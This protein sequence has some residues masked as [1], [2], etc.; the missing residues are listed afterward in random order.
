LWRSLMKSLVWLSMNCLLFEFSP[1]L[2][3]C[4]T[5]FGAGVKCGL[6]C[7]LFLQSSTYSIWNSFCYVVI[8]R[9]H[10]GYNDN[11]SLIHWRPAASRC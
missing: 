11:Y 10:Q 6:P 2:V 8:Y 4:F 5:I 3:V 7:S 9:N 1:C